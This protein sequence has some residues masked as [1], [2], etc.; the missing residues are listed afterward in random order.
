[1]ID[2]RRTDQIDLLYKII[3]ELGY[4]HYNN[5]HFIRVI[6]E[7]KYYDIMIQAEDEPYVSVFS[8]DFAEV[9]EDDLGVALSACNSLNTNRKLIRCFVRQKNADRKF[10]VTAESCFYYTDEES[11]KYALEKSFFM[12]ADIKSD[13][14]QCFEE[15]LNPVIRENYDDEDEE[16]DE[17][18]E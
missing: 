17:D 16:D 13:Y 12:L 2:L 14:F 5:E 18:D 7:M 3:D 9:K 15:V 4:P 11:F 10:Y 8:T 1:M 6:Y